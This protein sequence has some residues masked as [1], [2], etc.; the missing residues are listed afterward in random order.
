M[1]EFEFSGLESLIESSRA[2]KQQRPHITKAAISSD[3]EIGPRKPNQTE[4]GHHNYD[5]A[6][7]SD[8]KISKTHKQALL[9]QRALKHHKKRYHQKKKIRHWKHK[10]PRPSRREKKGQQRTQSRKQPMS[11]SQKI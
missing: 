11:R 4:F 1:R 10:R 2:K 5:T 7:A 9:Q 6:T 3:N 8:R